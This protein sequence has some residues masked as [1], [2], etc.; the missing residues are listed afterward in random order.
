MGLTIGDKVSRNPDSEKRKI[1]GVG[2]FGDVYSVVLALSHCF[3]T[4]GLF[5]HRAYLMS[6]AIKTSPAESRNIRFP[7]WDLTEPK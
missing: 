4:L 6:A 2:T 1:V 7:R 5:G 3:T